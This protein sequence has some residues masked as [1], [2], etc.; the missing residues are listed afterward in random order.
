MSILYKTTI[1]ISWRL[2]MR[3]LFLL[4]LS[5]IFLSNCSQNEPLQKPQTAQEIQKWSKALNFPK[6]CDEGSFEG[7]ANLPNLTFYT[8]GHNYYVSASCESFA[9]QN[10]SNLYHTDAT[11]AN[12]QLLELFQVELDLASINYFDENDNALTTPE[13]EVVFYRSKQIIHQSMTVKDDQ[14][15]ILRSYNDTGS[16]GTLSTYHIE[17]NH[18]K[19]VGLSLNADCESETKIPYDQW[20]HYSYKCTS[21]DPRSCQLLRP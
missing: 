1:L 19:L 13:F 17:E 20:K 3:H 14:L 10:V 4:L 18:A 7:D 8:L 5:M 9:Y 15:T 2:F 12:I 11:G 21:K 6:D 16:C